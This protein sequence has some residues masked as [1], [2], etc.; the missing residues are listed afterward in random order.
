M[1]HIRTAGLICPDC[2]SS[3]D[4]PERCA[5]CGLEFPLH[6]TIRKLMAQRPRDVTLTYRPTDPILPAEDVMRFPAR[7]GQSRGS[8][9]HLD[10]AHAEVL[11]ALPAG[12]R[13]LEVGC[14]GGQMRAWAQAQGLDYV[15]IDVASD[16]VHDWLREHGG[17]DFYADAHALPFED[18]RF[19]AVYASAV[20]EHLALPALATQE[21]L[22][23]LK[24]GGVMLGSMSFLEPWHDASQT[25]MTPAGVDRMLRLAGF[26]PRLIWP[27][28]RWSG[29]RA[30][31]EMGNKVT[32]FLRGLSWLIY[33]VYLAPKVAQ[34]L[35]RAR[36][37]PAWDDLYHPVA[38]I[39]GAVAWIAD[40][41]GPAQAMRP[42]GGK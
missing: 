16:R 14:G 7:S 4:S 34:H 42:E 6:G 30:I 21:A 11:A 17:P 26:A 32:R 8:V 25:H 33:G 22:R 19:D 36:R 29:F 3:L 37:W 40:K 20:W 27:E 13:I 2:H 12:S 1:E 39:A 23:V 41:P 38:N 15:G 35:I 10:R 5:A 28:I 24:P 31:M 18:A 9:Y